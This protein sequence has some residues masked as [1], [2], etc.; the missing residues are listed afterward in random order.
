MFMTFGFRDVSMTPKTNMMHHWRQNSQNGSR[1]S[2]FIFEKSISGNL[3]TENPQFYIVG[4]DMCR[5]S[6]QIAIRNY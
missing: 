6:L 1:K 4:R 3:K 5:K 2:R